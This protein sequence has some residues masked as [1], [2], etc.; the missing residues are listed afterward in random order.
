VATIS[1]LLIILSKKL[2]K[3]VIPDGRKPIWDHIEILPF[4]NAKS[5]QSGI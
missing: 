3:I 5:K 4:E 2:L 1:R